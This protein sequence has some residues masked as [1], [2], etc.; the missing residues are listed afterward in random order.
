MYWSLFVSALLS[1]TLQPGS[2]EVLLIYKL[3]QGDDPLLLLLSATSGNLLGSLVTYLMGIGGN[4]LIH[5]RWLGINELSLARAE[6]WFQRF[7]IYSLLLAWLPVIGDPLCLLAGLMKV[8]VMPFILLV[9]F[10]KALRYASIIYLV[11]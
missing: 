7:G 6:R 11:I 4:A 2:S 1:A 10:G 8:R 3:G 9:G 5:K